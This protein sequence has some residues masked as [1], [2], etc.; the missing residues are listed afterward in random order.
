MKQAWR[1]TLLRF[2]LSTDQPK[3]PKSQSKPLSVLKLLRLL[4]MLAWAF[5]VS[6]SMAQAQTSAISLDVAPADHHFVTRDLTTNLGRFTVE[7]SLNNT[8][9]G[10]LKLR[11]LSLDHTIDAT[12]LDVAAQREATGKTGAVPFSLS[13]DAPAR[14][15]TYRIE[16]IGETAGG[17]A[18]LYSADQL[19]VG[20]AYIVYGQ[21]NAQAAMYNGSAS[22]NESTNILTFGNAS[23]DPPSMSNDLFWYPAK[24]DI[25]GQKGFIGQWP[26]KMARSLLDQTGVPISIINGAVGGQTIL[27]FQRNDNNRTDLNTAYGRLLY[28]AQKAGVASSARAIFWYQGEADGSTDANTPISVYAQRFAA[29]YSDLRQDYPGAE[30]IYVFQIRSGC[31]TPSVQLRDLQRRF[32]DDYSDVQ[33]LSTTGLNGHDGCHFS[34][35]RGYENLGTQAFQLVARD[36]YGSQD[37]EGIDPPNVAKALFTNTIRS[38]ITLRFRDTDDAMLWEPGSEFY[39]KLEGSS[40]KVTGGR[41]NGA[42]V[43]MQLSGDGSGATGIS[44]L[45]HAGPNILPW[46][47]NTRGLGMLTFYNI[48]ILQDLDDDGVVDSEDNCPTISNPDQSDVDDDGTGDACDSEADGDGI[49]NSADNC[50]LVFNPGQEDLDRDGKGDVCDNDAD[51]DQISNSDDNC[52]AVPNADQTDT[53]EDGQGDACDSDADGDGIGNEVDNCPLVSNPDQADDDN[54]GF[55]NACDIDSDGD[56]LDDLD[57]NCPSIPNADQA[58]LDDDGVGDVCDTDVDGDQVENSVDNCPAVAN[59]DQAN[60]DGDALGDACD[61]DIDGDGIGNETDNCPIVANPGQEDDD[62]DGAGNACDDDVD[63]DGITDA[64]DNCPLVSN[65]DQSDIDEDDIG[66]VCD[67]DADGDGF[68]NDSDNCAFVAN[69]DQADSD[70]DGVG[71][72]CDLDSDGDNVDDNEDNCPG[73]ANP[74][75]ENVDGDAFGDAC[76]SDIDGDAVANESDNCPLDS[77]AEQADLDEDGVGNVC[78]PDLDGDAVDNEEDNCPVIAN[79]DQSDADR[80]GVGNACQEAP[81]RI[82]LYQSFPNPARGSA[83]IQFALPST[84]TVRLDL[85]DIAG[86]HVQTIASGTFEEGYH[87]IVVDVSALHGG[88]YVYMLTAGGSTISRKLVVI[89]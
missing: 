45:G 37:T 1:T 23:T 26:I 60:L 75:Q 74:G 52:P 34:Y 41:A 36:L 30:K 10:R 7:G 5:V 50:P 58:D 8:E 62:G 9:I 20:D 79:P 24:A 40:V 22:E 78:D 57:D 28:R 65:A 17:D 38:E 81:T 77:N 15:D 66:D 89:P 47:A 19:T 21:S 56:G 11:V 55:G 6:T 72:A 68:A 43:V 69:A 18:L 35:Q 51:G 12:A 85:F 13:V 2:D 82:G 29:L 54:D 49:Q 83:N 25:V 67:D 73:I 63:G 31:G 48:P 42:T 80:D 61:D 70:G 64:E 86:R 59:S 44:Y 39:F 71:N 88:T 33:V 87:A 3:P 32:E 16:L 46:V 84:S 27:Y 14:M 76:D 53:D 4:P